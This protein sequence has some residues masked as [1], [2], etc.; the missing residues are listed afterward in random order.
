MKLPVIIT[1]QP[2]EGMKVEIPD[3]GYTGSLAIGSIKSGIPGEGS[4]IEFWL[5]YDTNVSSNSAVWRMIQ[6]YSGSSSKIVFSINLPFIR[7]IEGYIMRL[8]RGHTTV[9]LAYQAAM[10]DE[11]LCELDMDMN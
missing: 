6:Q 5:E 4:T 11:Y 7:G 1:E 3:I 2:T 9:A 8:F 10:S